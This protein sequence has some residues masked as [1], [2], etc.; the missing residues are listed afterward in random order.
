MRLQRNRG[1]LL[2][3]DVRV[4]RRDQHQRLFDVLPDAIEV[5]LE[6][7]RAVQVE[8]TARIGEQLDRLEHVVQDHGLETFSW[9]W[10]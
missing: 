1:G 5:R 2:V 8:R 3:A 6:S 4:E 7:V 9:N 10:P